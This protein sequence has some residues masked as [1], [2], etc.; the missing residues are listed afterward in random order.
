MQHNIAKVCKSGMLSYVSI[1]AGQHE[2]WDR[3]EDDDHAGDG[4]VWG[5]QK[6]S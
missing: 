4:G 3:D 5:V 1:F 2:H 6:L